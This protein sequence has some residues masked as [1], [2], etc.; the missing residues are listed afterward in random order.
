MKKMSK[1]EA[2]A[3]NVQALEEEERVEEGLPALKPETKPSV[4]R[5][6]KSTVKTKPDA[7]KT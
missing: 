2:R 5:T 3:F 7:T 1:D 4:K 6:R